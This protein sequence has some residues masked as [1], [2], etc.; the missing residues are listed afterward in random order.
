LFKDTNTHKHTH[1]F[2]DNS[3]ERYTFDAEKWVP[4]G[5]RAGIDWGSGM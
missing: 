2:T 1:I 3:L 4:I 5:T